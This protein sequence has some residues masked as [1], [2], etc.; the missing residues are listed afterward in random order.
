[1]YGAILGDIIGSPYEF[2]KDFK[3]KEFDLFCEASRFT[4][5]TVMTVA[6]ADALLRVS[7][8][9]SSDEIKSEVI[10][11]MRYW[12]NKYPLVGYGMRFKS[13]LG[14]KDPKPYGSF[15]NGSAMRVSSVGYLYNTLE[16]TRE[17]AKLTAEVTHNHEE[18][19][20]GAEAVASAI[21]LMRSGATKKEL[22]EYIQD[23]FNYD[24]SRS[25]SE[26]RPEYS[27]QVSSEKS[28]PEAVIAF[29][30]GTSFEEVIRNAVSLGG[31]SDTQACIAGSIA[32]T[33]YEIRDDLISK[34]NTY[35]PKEM[36]EVVNEFY[37]RV[38]ILQ[39]GEN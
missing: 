13:W 17:V 26:I 25:L 38:H 14:S 29:L 35:L 18:G 23:N 32:E 20:K 9:A 36:I 34:A 39:A 10:N 6:V 19:I 3:S 22:K 37:K 4:D 21:F 8:D 2:V 28:V 27:H 31:D 5:D 11:R 15:G 7:G 30:E 16:R 33:V 24:L 12:G 1:M